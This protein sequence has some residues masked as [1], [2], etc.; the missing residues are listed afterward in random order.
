MTDGRSATATRVLWASYALCLLASLTH[1]AAAFGALENQ[2][3]GFR[4]VAWIAAL[5]VDAGLAAL[6][7]ASGERKRRGLRS[8][9]LMVGVALFCAVSAFANMDHALSVAPW[10]ALDTW[11]RARAVLLSV[12]LPCMV[13]Y[14]AWAVEQLGATSPVVQQVA[15][16]VTPEVTKRGATTR[17]AGVRSGA[18]MRHDAGQAAVQPT[19][20]Q[21]AIA[22]GVLRGGGTKAAAARAAGVD[23][24]TVTRWTKPGGVL[25]NY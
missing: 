4:H 19:T 14:L 3:S 12:T 8:W 24:A 15:P 10:G 13:V 6:A 7:W 20:A 16:E 25:T 5:G 23:A 1:V 21:H 11:G 18:A 2:A 17:S 22:A 9:P